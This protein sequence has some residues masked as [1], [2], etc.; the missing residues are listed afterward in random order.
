MCRFICTVYLNAQYLLHFNLLLNLHKCQA[1][2]FSI[3]KLSG[4]D[5]E[6]VDVMP[7]FSVEGIFV[8]FGGF[9]NTPTQKSL[10]STEDTFGSV[11]SCLKTG[12]GKNAN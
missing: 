11:K 7:V 5:C 12:I 8:C 10:Y 2:S 4:I 1:S 6:T 9:Y 3:D